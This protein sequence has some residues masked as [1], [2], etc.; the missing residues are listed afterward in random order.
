VVGLLKKQG[1]DIDDLEA[2][3]DFGCGCGRVIRHFHSLKRARLYGTDYN[4]KLIEWCKKNLPFAEFEVN[5]LSPP[6]AYRDSSF[7]LIYA[8]S[9]FTHL[10]EALQASWLAELS[11]VLKPGGYLLLTTHG[12]AYADAHLPPRERE[13]FRLGQLVVLND[14]SSGKNVCSA[15]HPAEYVQRKLAKGFEP[16]E[17]APGDVVDPGLRIIAQDI[18]LLKKS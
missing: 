9:V 13:H 4:V 11:R 2:I 7:G 12:A 10:S 17:F 16:V 6:L 1:V 5:R 8:F 14:D 3:L 18:Y 15:Y